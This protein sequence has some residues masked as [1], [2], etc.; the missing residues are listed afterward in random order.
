MWKCFDHNATFPDTHRHFRP[1]IEIS[2]SLPI[3]C[4]GLELKKSSLK[5]DRQ[6]CL[7]SP[8]MFLKCSM[9]KKYVLDPTSKKARVIECK[10]RIEIA[11]DLCIRRSLLFYT[12]GTNIT[13]LYL[14][15]SV[16]I[17]IYIYYL[18][19]H[20]YIYIYIY[21]NL[22]IYIYYL[23]ICLFISLIH[24][25]SGFGPIRFILFSCILIQMAAC[26]LGNHR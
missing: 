23:F 16:Y 10:F 13:G 6:T 15:A 9:F 2:W 18:S 5:N 25:S 3:V 21:I 20:I 7:D 1:A 24:V 19:L 11:S 8:P 17:Y 4:G 14:Y 12:L 26:H 22:Y